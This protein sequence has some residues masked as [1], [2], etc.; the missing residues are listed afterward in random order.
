MKSCIILSFLLLSLAGANAQGR[1]DYT[2]EAGPA[3]TSSTTKNLVLLIGPDHINRTIQ[4]AER[5]NN[6]AGNVKYAGIQ[7]LYLQ[8]MT[9]FSGP[10][11][12][13]SP[14]EI[15]SQ[16]NNKLVFRVPKVS[17]NV[18]EVDLGSVHESA[19]QIGV[20]VATISFQ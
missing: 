19:N 16:T 5:E 4:S 17:Q 9:V 6:T 2:A 15:I 13:R 7:Y 10:V 12:K 11:V 14:V 1:E 3:Y 8:N 18:L 20:Q